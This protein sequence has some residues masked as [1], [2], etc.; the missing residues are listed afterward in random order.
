MKKKPTTW[1][2]VR[3]PQPW[4][5]NAGDEIVGEYLGSKM[6]SGG[7]GDY[8]IHLIKT[9]RKVIVSVSGAVAD[10]LFDLVKHGDKIKCVYLGRRK[11]RDSDQEYKDYEL[12]TEEEIQLKLAEV[13]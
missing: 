12:Y 10:G 1:Y 5:P 8:K 4:R 7:F 6:K 13:G 9:G 2:R 11:S 3:A